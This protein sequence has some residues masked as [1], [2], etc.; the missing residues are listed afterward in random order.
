MTAP[1]I[2]KLVEVLS[3]EERIHLEL[4]TLLTQERG[5][6]L[7]LDAE[8][9]YELATRKEI[10]AEEG[11]LAGRARA[12]VIA[13]LA[14]SLG[15]DESDI[16]LTRICAALGAEADPLRAARSRLLSIVGAVA[17]LS[18]ANQ[19]LGGDRLSDV[20]T[21]LELLGRLAPNLAG[22]ST[23]RAGRLVQRSA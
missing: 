19:R 8:S 21:T 1:M 3:V 14:E 17:E 5:R 10:L 16:T 4:R 11:R 23:A 6:M 15:L 7:E 12:R 13:Q 9:L 20:Q 22:A 2:A 18:E